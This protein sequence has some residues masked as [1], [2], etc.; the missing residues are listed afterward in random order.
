MYVGIAFTTPAELDSADFGTASI[1][2]VTIGNMTEDLGV[3]GYLP[4]AI[5]FQV[6]Q[7]ASNFYSFDDSAK[8]VTAGLTVCSITD[9]DG[10]QLS[11]GEMSR[12]LTVLYPS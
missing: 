7:S 11:V 6:T 8:D 2:T 3:D 10:T 4:D 9:D 12:P 1:S 5:F